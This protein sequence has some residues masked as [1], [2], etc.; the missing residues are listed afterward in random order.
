VI[1]FA[2]LALAL[3]VAC[4]PDAEA[5][6]P[7]DPGK[8]AAKTDAAAKAPGAPAA[9]GIAKIVFVD[10]AEACDCTTKRIAASWAALSSVVGDPPSI[11]VERIH[12]DTEP[13]KA[14]VYEDLRPLV[15]PPGI[16][17]LDD[18]EA[19]VELLQGEVTAE[20]IAAVLR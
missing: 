2:I 19:V 3:A 16:Y 15:V 11:A 7:A 13:E 18:K 1:P 17:F 4:A 6:K 9:A 12:L 14:D 8:T 10:Q 20:Q 5:P